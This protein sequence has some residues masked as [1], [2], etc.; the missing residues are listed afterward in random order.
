MR[1][2]FFLLLTS[3]VHAQQPSLKVKRGVWFQLKGDTFLLDS[4]I[5]EDSSMLL[6]DT[7]Y[8]SCFIR[9]KYFSIGNNVKIIGNGR[10]GDNGRD[11]GEG[12]LEALDVPGK[13]GNHGTHGINL[14]LNF[15]NL[16]LQSALEIYL[17]GG[18]GGKGGTGGNIIKRAPK[19]LS[20]TPNQGHGGN[21]GDGG[22]GGEVI[23]SCPSDLEKIIKDKIAI[24]SSGGI[25]GSSGTPLELRIP[26]WYFAN[27]R[28]GQ[29]GNEG[30][31]KLL[32][33]KR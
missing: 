26:K 10:D 8:K 4:L 19:N 30:K 12:S 15:S 14:T 16:E 20:E 5:M 25:G 6:L 33:L 11:G 17:Y 9:I 21:G 18:R 2:I 32:Y 1:T 31:I 7:R 27:E 3:V 22:N 28:N 23:V 29:P 13:D 24:D